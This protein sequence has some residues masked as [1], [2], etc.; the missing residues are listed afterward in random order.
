MR[1]SLKYLHTRKRE[2]GEIRYLDNAA[3]LGLG[4]GSFVPKVCPYFKVESKITR[5]FAAQC[6]MFTYIIILQHLWRYSR[7]N[8]RHHL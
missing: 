1:W 5:D 3:P 6:L 4:R 2:L 8:S 7:R